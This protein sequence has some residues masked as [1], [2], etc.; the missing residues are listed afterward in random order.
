MKKD[1]R[2]LYSRMVHF[3]YN[4][5]TILLIR[6]SFVKRVRIM[7]SELDNDQSQTPPPPILSIS[8]TGSESASAVLI[9]AHSRCAIYFHIMHT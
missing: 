8:K 4:P 5:K 9:M 7:H 6:M 1:R 3:P 2:S